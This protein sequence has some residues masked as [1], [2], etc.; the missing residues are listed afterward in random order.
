MTDAV[1]VALI[2]GIP[3]MLTALAAAILSLRNGFKADAAATAAAS[4]NK[5]ALDTHAI[6]NSQR[7]E[8][9]QKIAA[10]QAEIVTLVREADGRRRQ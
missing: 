2:V 8:M 9:L 7:E 5:V 3:P 6:V 1:M 10:L 4:A